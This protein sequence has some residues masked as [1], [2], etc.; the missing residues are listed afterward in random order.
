MT[1]LDQL[2]DFAAKLKASGFVPKSLKSTAQV[3]IAL[4]AGAEVGLPPMQ[5]LR[6]IAPIN[7]SPCLWGEGAKALVL[8]GGKVA[9]WE[10]WWEVDGERISTDPTAFTESTT[11]VTRS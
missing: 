9:E 6:Y 10:D 7:G 1:S 5:S 4:Q 3:V 11:A 8:T 2:N